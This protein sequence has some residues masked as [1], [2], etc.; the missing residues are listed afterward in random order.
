MNIAKMA[1]KSTVVDLD[2]EAKEE[3][4]LYRDKTIGIILEK[5]PAKFKSMTKMALEEH[6]D[7]RFIV[8]NTRIKGEISP[9]TGK[10]YSL[11]HPS[12]KL[13]YLTEAEA[14]K[15][16]AEAN[17]AG[18]ISRAKA[19]KRK[20]VR[21]NLSDID[22]NF[23]EEIAEEVAATT[24][25]SNLKRLLDGMVLTFSQRL[26]EDKTYSQRR[27]ILDKDIQEL[28][29]VIE[30][31]E[32]YTQDDITAFGQLMAKLKGKPFFS[33]IHEAQLRDIAEM[34]RSK[35]KFDDS[36]NASW[37]DSIKKGKASQAIKR[38]AEKYLKDDLPT[39]LTKAD[40]GIDWK[41]VLKAHCGS[42]EK[43]RCTGCPSC[44][45]EQFEKTEEA[46]PDYIDLDGDGDKKESMKQ[47]AKDKKKKSRSAFT[48]R[49]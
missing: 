1:V 31:D 15:R 4:Y 11:I 3:V 35:Y 7:R 10:E 23:A 33:G 40:I 2:E 27:G 39:D 38:F 5:V 42:T 45:K 28:K 13:G 36:K 44:E 14:E 22:E 16:V 6:I 37:R 20:T 48:D 17:K 18:E 9:K 21:E 30:T 32:S 47:A 34:M 43:G 12:P 49:D 19:L 41:E 29:E 8:R 46:K 25:D 26:S 24:K